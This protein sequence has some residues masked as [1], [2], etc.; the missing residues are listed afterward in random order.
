MTERQGEQDLEAE[1]PD[2]AVEQRPDGDAGDGDAELER[3]GN[4]EMENAELQNVREPDRANR[5]L[6]P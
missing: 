3:H 1:S 6:R 2:L 4:V 5:D